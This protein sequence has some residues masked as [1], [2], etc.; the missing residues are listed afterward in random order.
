VFNS[1]GAL[2][3]DF[4]LKNLTNTAKAHEDFPAWGPTGRIA[5]INRTSDY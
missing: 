5:Y 3:S 1:D 4:P 2:R